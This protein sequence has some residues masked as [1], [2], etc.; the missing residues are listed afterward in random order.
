ML[1]RSLEATETTRATVGLRRAR[2]FF[3]M[4]TRRQKEHEKLFVFVGIFDMWNVGGES[5]ARNA[6]S[7]W[8][9]E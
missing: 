9:G 4:Y 7:P 5:G 8:V 6:R 1:F 3:L 2:V